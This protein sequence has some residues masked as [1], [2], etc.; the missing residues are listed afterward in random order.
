MEV[1]TRGRERQKREEGRNDK[2]SDS[3]GPSARLK[4]ELES[5]RYL[6]CVLADRE[7]GGRGTKK[8]DRVEGERQGRQKGWKERGKE[9][10]E[11]GGRETRKTDR[12]EGE[13]KLRQRG[14]R[15]RDKED[16]ER[17][18]GERQERQRG[19]KERDKEDREGG[20]RRG[21]REKD[22]GDRE[23]G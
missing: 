13:R 1:E 12:A 4:G 2:R 19:W 7:E 14:W 15:E 9:D 18:E 11:G 3:V 10:S 6:Q 20:G 23:G 22:K 8:T 17:V 5:S 21:W 16:R